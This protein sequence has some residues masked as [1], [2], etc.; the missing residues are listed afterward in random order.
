MIARFVWSLLARRRTPGW[1]AHLAVIRRVRALDPG[2]FRAWQDERVAA[3]L[4]WARATL[5]YWRDRIPARAGLADLPILTRRDVQEH[6]EAL[7]DPTRPLETLH[8]DA[9]GG[10]TGEPVRVWHDDDYK[11]WIEAS[12]FHVFETWGL[13]PW[14]STAVVWGSDRDLDKL[15]GREKLLN[16]LQGRHYFNA[17]HMGDD[18]LEQFAEAF[19]RIRPRY[20]QGYAGALDVFARHLIARG[21]AGGFGIRAIRSSAEVLSADARARIEEAFGAPVYDYY[22]SRESACLAAECAEGGFHVLAH[23]RRLELVDD[24][25]R[26]VGPGEEGRVLVTDFTNRAFGVIRYETGDVATWAAEGV[27][28]C[29]APY[30]RLGAIRGRTSDFITTTAGERIHG[31]WFT[32][33][34]YGVPGVARFQVRQRDLAHLDVHTVGSATETE[35]ADV[36]DAIRERMGPE[37]EVRWTR[38]ARIAETRSGKRRFTVSDVPYLPGSAPS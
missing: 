7:R 37:T 28:A 38:V 30:P 31:E 4:A 16:R 5:P 12:E 26:P 32:H 18:D 14:C 15:A 1:R 13:R 20:L 10:S 34:F 9:S 22:G 35:L 36:L 21:R 3:H 23:G 25:G 11:A 2:A 8:E 6:A 33:L 27:C 17:F 19:E 29:G 24:A